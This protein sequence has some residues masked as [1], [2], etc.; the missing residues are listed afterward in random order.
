M[1]ELS[2]LKAFLNREIYQQY[3]NF[4]DLDYFS[5]PLKPLLTCIDEW[6][7][8]NDR[9]LSLEDL[10]NTFFAT[11]PKNKE[12]Y[13]GVFLTLDALKAP[14]SVKTVLEAIKNKKLCEDISI[15]FYEAST[16]FKPLPEALSLVEKLQEPVQTEIEFLD[17]DLERILNATVKTPGLRWRLDCLNKSLGSLRK[18]DLGFI[19]ARPETGKTTLLVDQVTFMA[20]QATR[21]VVYF[22]NEEQ[23][24]KVLLRMYQAALGVELDQ[25]SKSPKEAKDIFH[26]ITK[27]NIKFYDQAL[28]DKNLVEAVCKRYNPSL[29]V[30][31]QLDKIVGFKADREDLLLG[32]IYQW[33]RELAK[34]YAPVIGVCQ[35][36]GE[37]DGVTYLTMAHVAGSKTAKQAEADWILGIGRDLRPE[38]DRVR[39]LSVLKNKLVGDA[40][41]VPAMRHMQKQVLLKADIARYIDFG[42]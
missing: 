5:D 25:L 24:D 23:G 26:D 20:S 30:F 8:G 21:P 28:I 36:S 27:K 13:R 14:E 34:R 6:Y 37:A 19:F 7:T 1:T 18:G 38:F 3:R 29:I 32:K 12:E 15:A 10:S 39:F 41:S 35:A 33:A 22:N 9:E 40:D 2:I 42:D 11:L 17:D 4:L 31:D 16:G